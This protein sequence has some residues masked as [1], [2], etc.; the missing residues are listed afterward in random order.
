MCG[1]FTQR[2]SWAEL[3]ELMDLIGAPL[4]LQPRYNIAP[5]Q[6]VAIV[7]AADPGSQSG[8]AAGG[9]RRLSML[10]WGLIPAWAKY[11][12]IGNRL[13]N[14]QS[15]TV[16]EKPAFRA[17]Y[18]R[19]RCLVP[20]DG[21]YEWQRSPPRT[22]IRG[23]GTRQPWLFG[24]RD[25]STFAFAGLWE[26][27]TAPEGPAPAGSLFGP[28]LGGPVETFTILTTAANATVAAV[29][30]RMPVILPPDAYGPWLAGEDIP[31]GPCPVDEMYAYP[32]STLVNRPANDEPR[33]VELVSLC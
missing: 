1:R 13:I 20:A 5:G 15:E 19:R 11:Q 21:F 7:R 33:C 18:R 10:R 17:A 26:R 31:L 27:W 9:G 24:L 25:G 16:A 12:S 8:A 32:V 2:L 6:D 23:A 30:G 4:N 3:H 29:H 22:A 28:E 14:A